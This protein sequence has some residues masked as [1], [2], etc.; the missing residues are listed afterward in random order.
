MAATAPDP[1]S[2]PTPDP[3][4][5]RFEAL[6]TY[7]HVAASDPAQLGRAV[8]VVGDVLDLVDA[9]C[10]RFRGDSDLARVNA[11]AGG[12]VVAD[13]V[14]V[15][16]VEVALAAAHETDG[17]VDPCLGLTLVSLGY[18]ADLA[19]VRRRGDSPRT[20]VAHPVGAWREVRVDAGAVRVPAGV[21]LDLGA[22]AKAWA[23]DV[24]AL[25]ASEAIG[26]GVVVS[27]GGDVRIVADEHAPAWP[28]AVSEHPDAADPTTVWVAGGGVA[29]SST[30]VRRWR[31]GGVERHHVADPRTGRPVAGPWRT[32]TATG[33]T[34]VAANVAT[35]AALVLGE[36]A[37][38]WLGERLVDARLVDHAGVV[39]LTGA[40]PADDEAAA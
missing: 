5:R 36:E 6:G 12:W 21:A 3:A 24:A 26:G 27:V 40:W 22:T 17:L 29:T 13:P 20:P 18:D 30:V 25:A 11:G 35:T 9:T 16:A 38:D 15:A 28:V 39:H 14:L 23:A 10:S 34:S 1:A 4:H 33:P 31:A 7:V 37:L 8:E 19:V 2:D 32:V